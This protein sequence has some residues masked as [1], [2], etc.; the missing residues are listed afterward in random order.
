MEQPPRSKGYRV[1]FPYPVLAADI[2]GTNARFALIAEPGDSPSHAVHRP[3]RGF[4]DLESAIEDA[5][6]EL[7]D[8]P[9]S[10]IACAAG[11]VEGRRVVMTNA[12][13]TIDGAGVAKALGLR[14]GLL[15]NDFEAQ[16]LSLPI[17]RDEWVE[18]IGK[19]RPKA[20]GTK[21]I[22]GPGTG[23]GVAAL[24][25]IGGKHFALASEAGHV[26]FG[27]MGSEESAIWPHLPM[28]PLGRISAEFLMSGPG[29]VRLH[30]ARLTSQ[31]LIA[32]RTLD[33]M[34][35]VE[36]GRA[37]P[38]GEEANTIRLFWRLTARFA[39]D[40][41]L[42]F[43]ATGGVTFSGGVL[44][45]VIAFADPTVFRARFEDKAPFGELLRKIDTRLIV[46]N[47]TVLHG[48]NAIAARPDD[49]AIDY[50]GR[51]WC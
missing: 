46:A 11:P 2:G 41:A 35:L 50:A 30:Q 26:D 31:G 38:H 37:N 20:Q 14:Q 1:E 22:L 39:G 21:L 33:E 8:T 49:Y 40:M 23:L 4:P 29:L 34:H 43:L 17:I 42:A 45:R 51:A 48:M 12:N 15:L 18:T 25:E 36:Q 19:A 16:A 32:S 28:T 47:D 10:I 5:L 27:P 6:P 3:T 24:L 9:R 7:P 13:W 44:P